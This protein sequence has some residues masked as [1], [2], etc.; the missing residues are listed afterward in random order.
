[1]YGRCLAALKVSEG[2]LPVDHWQSACYDIAVVQTLQL[3]T[4]DKS[5]G[6]LLL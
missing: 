6:L 3:V 2:A 1:M 4:Y 5:L